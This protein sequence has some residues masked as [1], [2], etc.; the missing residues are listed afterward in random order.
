M[1]NAQKCVESHGDRFSALAERSRDIFIRWIFD[2]GWHLEYVSPAIQ[3]I[4]GLSPAECHTE[5]WSLSECVCV[6][7][8]TLADSLW[9]G[10]LC[11]P[12]GDSQVLRYVRQ[13]K[14]IV[15]IDQ[16]L[17]GIPDAEGKV[18]AIEGLLRDI[19][20]QH[21]VEEALRTPVA[22]LELE[23]DVYSRQLRSSEALSQH[24]VDMIQH[25][26]K[27]PLCDIIYCA[28]ILTHH[29]Q[30]LSYQ[31]QVDYLKQIESSATYLNSLLDKLPL[32]QDPSRHQYLGEKE[33]FEAYQFCE[34]II[35]SLCHSSG[36]QFDIGESNRIQFHVTD[37][38]SPITTD[39]TFLRQILTNLLSNALKYSDGVV[40]LRISQE[41]KE[42]IRF[43]IGDEG[44]GISEEEQEKVFMPFHRSQTT[45]EEEGKGLGL[46]IVQEAVKLLGGT[47]HLQSARGRGSIFTVILPV[48]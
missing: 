25:E 13:D 42:Y 31:Q 3:S 28:E 19:T 45:Q 12:F 17:I 9:Q 24:L 36:D 39:K 32:F 41:G 16:Q 30:K 1:V 33:K 2:T 47:L 6:Q 43:A 40:T 46:S 23:V 15:W 34:E 7:D 22:E 21:Q 11:P 35:K 37:H 5:G 38:L 48:S 10:C 8:Q 26:Y 27:T 18:T 20:I 14:T 44:V 29:L 4:L